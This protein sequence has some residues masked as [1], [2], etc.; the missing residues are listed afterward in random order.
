[1]P[2]SQNWTATRTAS[3]RT[4]SLN[5]CW[6]YRNRRVHCMS[7]NT[8]VP[9]GIGIVRPLI[10]PEELNEG[11]MASC[12]ELLNWRVDRSSPTERRYP[13]GTEM[14]VLLW[15]E[16]NIVTH[17]LAVAPKGMP[18]HNCNLN[19]FE[20]PDSDA[21]SCRGNPAIWVISLTRAWLSASTEYRRDWMRPWTRQSTKLN[22]KN[23]SDILLSVIRWYA[24]FSES[25]IKQI[26]TIELECLF[27][28]V[29]RMEVA[30]PAS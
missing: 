26:V 22:R 2:N 10:F 1:M 6:G 24:D 11:A 3:S 16:S 21:I 28:Q 27:E 12:S 9:L 8:V 17:V 19:S 25:M 7:R 20:F 13:V 18:V 30:E 14:G 29:K 4:N 15:R 5:C 23:A